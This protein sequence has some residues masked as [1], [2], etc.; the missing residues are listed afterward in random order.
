[1][2]RKQKFGS[3][4]KPRSTRLYI[5][6]LCSSLPTQFSFINVQRVND[7]IFITQRG[8]P[9]CAIC[10]LVIKIQLRSANGHFE[11]RDSYQV[12]NTAIQLIFY[13]R[14]CSKSGLFCNSLSSAFSNFWSSSK[15]SSGLLGM[16]SNSIFSLIANVCLDTAFTLML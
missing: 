8:L 10:N 12:P 4:L 11:Q 15:F 7:A 16:T 1:M 13:R 3:D 5:F 6:D 9:G 14:G 2:R